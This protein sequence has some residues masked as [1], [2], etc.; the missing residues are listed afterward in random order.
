MDSTWPAELVACRTA[1][2]GSD[3]QMNAAGT[4]R[5]EPPDSRMNKEQQP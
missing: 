2:G 3:L 1:A 4:W 5:M